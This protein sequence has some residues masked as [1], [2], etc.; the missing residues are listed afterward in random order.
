MKLN[1][2]L[3]ITERLTAPTAKFFQ[4]IVKICGAITIITTAIIAYSNNMALELN[5]VGIVLDISAFLRY[6][7]IINAVVTLISKLTVDWEEYAKK[8]GFQL[9]FFSKKKE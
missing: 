7:A 2:N 4:P 5:S 6:V 9:V 1:Q 3:S 8:Q